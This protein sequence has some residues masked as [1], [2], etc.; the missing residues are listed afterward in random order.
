MANCAAVAHASTHNALSRTPEHRKKCL[1]Y[2]YLLARFFVVPRCLPELCL[3]LGRNRI[4]LLYEPTGV[5]ARKFR[6]ALLARGREHQSLSYLE[7]VDGTHDE[8]SRALRVDG[9]LRFLYGRDAAAG[10]VD[11]KC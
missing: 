3:W 10:R 11:V 4:V 2:H 9:R 7:Q 6:G 1:G 5:V 8:A